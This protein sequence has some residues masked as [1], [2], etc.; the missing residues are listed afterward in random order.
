MRKKLSLLSNLFIAFMSVFAWLSMVLRRHSG[1]LMTAGWGSLKYFTVLS[2]LLNALVSLG[3]AAALLRVLLGRAPG[4]SRRLQCAKL[5]ATAAVAL[6]FL[7]V[8]AFLGPLYG[9]P[10]MYQGANLWLHLCLP[11]LGM[12]EF[13]LLDSGPALS[14][15]DGLWA[16]L[17]AL[18]YGAAYALNL[19]INGV[20]A[21]PHSNDWYG[22]LNWGWGVGFAI[23]ALI[24]LASWLLGLLL[25]AANRRCAGSSAESIR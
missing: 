1:M 24:V 14:R 4:I 7:V 5:S 17:P 25:R 3:Y 23:F 6:T 19:A 15:R 21:R 12:L 10:F 8:A 16:G 20:G 2:N 22:F 11:V 13:A 18:L 9:Y